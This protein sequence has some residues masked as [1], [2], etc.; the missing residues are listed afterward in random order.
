MGVALDGLQLAS[1]AIDLAIPQKTANAI[2]ELRKCLQRR[3]YVVIAPVGV[4]TYVF[5]QNG[6]P[7]DDRPADSR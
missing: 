6:L 5:D 2:V 3:L 7:L 1:D 4:D